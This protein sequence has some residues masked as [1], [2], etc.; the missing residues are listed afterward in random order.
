MIICFKMCH[1]QKDGDKFPRICIYIER[2]VHVNYF[3]INSTMAKNIEIVNINRN[4]LYCIILDKANLVVLKGVYFLR[5]RGNIFW[6][7]D[8]RFQSC[9]SYLLLCYFYESTERFKIEKI[10]CY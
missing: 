3:S 4:E 5:G 9:L 8:V 1:F 7:S 2:K 10:E 6:C